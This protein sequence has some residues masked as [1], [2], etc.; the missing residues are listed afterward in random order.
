MMNG[1]V[2]QGDEPE[3]HVTLP[4][5][6]PIYLT[7]LTAKGDGGQIAF[8]DDIYGRDSAGASQVAALR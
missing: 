4:T 5:P 7:Y 3:E 1:N 8:V 2:P 6:V